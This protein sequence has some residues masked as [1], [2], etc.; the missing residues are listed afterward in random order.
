MD[1]NVYKKALPHIKIVWV[2][3]EQ[4]YIHFVPD[5][6]EVDMENLPETTETNSQEQP[7]KPS[8]KK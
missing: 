8:K 3:D 2:K 1:L 5:A 7:V 4:I 6:V